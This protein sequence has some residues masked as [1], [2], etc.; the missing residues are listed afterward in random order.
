MLMR[1]NIKSR[2][3]LH[4]GFLT[5]ASIKRGP[6]AKGNPT[7]HH[8]G[9]TKS[10]VDAS[11][12]KSF[13]PHGLVKWTEHEV[14]L[15]PVRPLKISDDPEITPG[16]FPRLGHSCTAIP[17]APGEFIVFG[18]RTGRLNQGVE[19]WTNDVNLLS[20]K[21]MSLTHL[22]TYGTKPDPRVS[23]RAVIAGRVLVIF[24]GTS[25]DDYLH[26]LN[27]GEFFLSKL[28]FPGHD[29]SLVQ[30]LVNGRV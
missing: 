10:D 7:L 5:N 11:C 16:V 30:I 12:I 1:F 19:T 26:F 2:D 6:S 28:R 27:L 13:V 17:D 8:G 9:N 21:D 15:R 29:R 14:E 20:T 24:G 23:H 4:Q 18:G 25:F 22:E 3:P